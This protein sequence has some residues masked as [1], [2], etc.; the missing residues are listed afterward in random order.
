MG[1]NTT[2]VGK[3]NS[4]GEADVI[5]LKRGTPTDDRHIACI[6]HPSPC[7]TEE[8][9]TVHKSGKAVE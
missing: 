8:I 6:E 2:D 5:G 9:E 1:R 4:V 3:H 7:F